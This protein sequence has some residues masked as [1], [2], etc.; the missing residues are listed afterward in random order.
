M[1]QKGMK[2]LD[3]KAW[4]SFHKIGTSLLPHLGRQ[5]TNHSGISS[6]EYVVLVALSE[7]LVPS[8]NLNRLA[9][10]LGWEISRMSHQI[11]RME[12]AGLIKKTK[13]PEDSR[14]FD[15]SITAKGRKIADAA[16]PLQ[17]KEINHCFSEVLTQTQMKSL[18]EISEAISSHMKKNHPINKKVDH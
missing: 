10:G 4:R 17:S 16:I 1:T 7:L 13:N 6:A 3:S 2:D 9:T 18:I 11:S 15:V 14:C 5:V 8:V 12:D